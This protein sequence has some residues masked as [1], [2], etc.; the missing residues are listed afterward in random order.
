M[1]WPT[2]YISIAEE[3]EFLDKYLLLEKIRFNNSFS[4]HIN[5][6]IENIHDTLIPP[7]LLQPFIENAVIHGL[8]KLK[9][10]KGNLEVLLKEE[11]ETIVCTIMDNGIGRESALKNRS[12]AHKSVA[13]SNLETR[14]EL[15]NSASNANEYT[16]EIIDLF[17]KDKAAGTKVIITFPNDL[18]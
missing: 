4:Y 17:E 7:M 1:P 9:D 5:E 10:R 16:Y 11:D 18:H 2:K 3:I 6:D 8:S 13:I 14:M 12:S 15:L